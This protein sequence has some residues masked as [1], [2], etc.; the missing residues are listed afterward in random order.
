MVTG[1]S[2][3][4]TPQRDIA[5]DPSISSI[6]DPSAR[7]ELRRGKPLAASDIYTRRAANTSAAGER[8]DYLL[9]AAE[10]LFDRAMYEEG[11]PRLSAVPDNLSTTDL[12]ARR[13]ILVAKE[14]LYKDDP[15]GALLALPDPA[16]MSEPLHRARTFETQAMSYHALQDP[17][18]E[19]NARIQLEEQLDNPTIIEKNHAAIWQ[20]LTTLP[21]SAL[22]GMTTNVRGDT[23]QGWIELALVN[24]DVRAGGATRSDALRLWQDRFPDHPANEQF[25]ANL[26][27]PDETRTM[28]F[29]S[30][31]INQIAVLLPISDPRTA[32]VA[33]AIRD[34]IIAAHQTD[35][36]PNAP[37]LRFYDIGENPGYVRTAYETAVAD[38]ADAVVGPLRKQS[39]AAIVT[40]RQ[41]PVPTI[42]LNTV[43]SGVI[44]SE[45]NENVIQF[46]LAP[47]D[48][49]RSAAS[50]AIGLS[51][52]NAIV[53][54]ADDSRGDREARAF[55]DSMFSYGGDVVHV[56]VLPSDKYDYSEEIR[57]ALQITQSDQR[58]KSLSSTIGEKLF[59]EPS[60]RNDVDVIF[61]AVSSEQ[62][63]SLRPQLD[64]FHATKV[65]RLGTSRVASIED[66]LKKNKD[67]NSIYYPDAPWVLR[68][69]M[70]KDPLRQEIINNFSGA[71][72]V[73]AKIYALG[74]DAYNVT[75]RLDPLSRGDRLSGYTGDLEL[76]P[77]GRI[78]RF[79][80][81]AQYQEGESVGVKSINAEPLQSIQPGS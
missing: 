14:L 13:S 55:Q 23:Y 44:M 3:C 51:L 60:I 7:R 49:A 40:M 65:P 67:L 19:L 43:D 66:N 78:Q 53:L 29:A 46:G 42:T 26:Y 79:L 10:I 58:F 38:G 74:I 12:Q 27:N 36:R 80:D 24:A 30:G 9:I 59:F 45:N 32:R 8:E 64:F 25:I 72:G 52:R 70:R 57:N 31:P 76:T 71:D 20:R 15:E 28:D 50:R 48:E 16:N 63:R 61:L 11:S 4:A 35:D 41:I 18:N 75:I 5:D 77:E 73:F 56:A 69:S 62:A 81:W 54:Q 1:L 22:N 68:K 47:E 21:M 34:G 37:V 2:A 17:D 39:V 33:A 6:T